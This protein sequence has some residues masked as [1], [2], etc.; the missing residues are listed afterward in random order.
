MERGELNMKSHPLLCSLKEKGEFISETYEKFESNNSEKIKAKAKGEFSQNPA[1]SEML[2]FQISLENQT[3]KELLTQAQEILQ[4][5]GIEKQNEICLSF[6]ESF[7]ES[8]PD[9]ATLL[10]PDTSMDNF[11]SQIIKYIQ[12]GLS[13][14]LSDTDYFDIEHEIHFPHLF[15]GMEHIIGIDSLNTLRESDEDFLMHYFSLEILMDYRNLPTLYYI[16][17][18]N[19][20]RLLFGEKRV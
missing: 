18:I 10:A 2:L 3:R 12:E 19:L 11:C 8:P 16:P 13:F 1:V 4:Q 15:R 9:P 14:A 7:K 6:I 20:L 17:D 5:A